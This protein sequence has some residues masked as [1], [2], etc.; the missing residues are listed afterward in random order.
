MKGGKQIKG[1]NITI[2]D[3]TLIQCLD[4]EKAYKDHGI[5]AK[6]KIVKEYHR[7]L[8]LILRS[9]LNSK[10]KSKNQVVLGYEVQGSKEKLKA[11]SWQLRTRHS[12][13][14][15][16]TSKI[17]KKQIDGKVQKRPKKATYRQFA[18]C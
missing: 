10:N 16:I 7:G 6:E 2:D 11:W 8:R 12:I 13:P 1:Q 4:E 9:E 14:D 3:K 17:L 15:T 18:R 5:D